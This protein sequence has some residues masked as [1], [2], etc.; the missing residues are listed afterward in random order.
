MKKIFY[1]LFILI[2]CFSISVFA[3][4]VN[5]IDPDTNVSADVLSEGEEETGLEIKNDL[6]ETI[7][8]DEYNG[9]DII[10]GSDIITNSD[11]VDGE[12]VIGDVD[13]YSADEEDVGIA[14]ESIEVVDKE[15]FLKGQE[16]N[17]T[18][19]ITTIGTVVTEKDN[20]NTIRIILLAVI[21]AV[22]FV[23]CLVAVNKYKKGSDESNVE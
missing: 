12:E 5:S 7:P 16:F 17:S 14:I 3:S 18:S 6:E 23:L 21:V 8:N 9:I 2:F 19:P 13:I 20:N 1:L 11:F 22:A 15:E 4:E 10:G